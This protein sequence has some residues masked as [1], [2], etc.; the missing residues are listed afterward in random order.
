M[1]WTRIQNTQFAAATAAS[2]N[3]TFATPTLVGSLLIAFVNSPGGSPTGVSDDK[4]N[5]WK[6]LGTPLV[7]NISQI[8]YLSSS[9]AGTSVV[10]ATSNS[11]GN[12][13]K[14]SIAEYTGQLVSH[15]ADA[16]GGIAIVGQ[17][18]GGVVSQQ[19]GDLIVQ[20]W[21]TNGTV[22]TW[23]AVTG[24]T[25]ET[26]LTSVSTFWGDNLSSVAGNNATSANMGASPDCI[27]QTGA[28]LPSTFTVPPGINV[29]RASETVSFL[30]GVQSSITS[31]IAGGNQAG[32]AILAVVVGYNFSV[33][34]VTGIT[35]TV[36]NT[37]SLLSFQHGTNTLNAAISVYIANPCAGF[38][39][40]N[41]ITAAVTNHTYSAL[42]MFCVEISGQHASPLDTV[43]LTNAA[44]ATKAYSIT[45]AAANELIVTIGTAIS[46]A[47]WTPTGQTDIS[48]INNVNSGFAPS[49]SALEVAASKSVAGANAMSITFGSASYSIVALTLKAATPVYSITGSL[50][51]SGAGATVA[52]TGASSG[53]TTADGSGNYN[54]GIVLIAGSYTITPTKPGFTFTPTSSPQTVS[55]NNITGV[56]F[57]A[58]ANA[59]GFAYSFDC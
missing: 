52:W 9:T 29:V 34:L 16:H 45:A 10:T 59:S 41:T 36:G 39:G 51:A 30:T 1:A 11:A 48:T 24:I 17:P 18:V 55:T 23:S 31:L 27:G 32:N 50:G 20:E 47:L 40:N 25:P 22:K 19:A 38:D 26:P 58:A 43:S 14:L 44:T 5:T 7:A 13:M 12:A 56:N 49:G 8:Y 28:F 21:T 57:T 37:Y 53:S 35:D 42:E 6:P 4:G 15:P 2:L 46:G 3:Q 33:D 54:T